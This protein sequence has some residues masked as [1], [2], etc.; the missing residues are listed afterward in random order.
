[1]YVVVRYRATPRSANVPPLTP[2]NTEKVYLSRGRKAVRC[3]INCFE[4]QVGNED[5][6][7]GRGIGNGEEGW[8]KVDQVRLAR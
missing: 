5:E 3:K 8:W 1:M 6:I 7:D 2:L 4:K